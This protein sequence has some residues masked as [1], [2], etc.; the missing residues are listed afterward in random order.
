MK[1]LISILLLGVLLCGMVLPASAAVID[2]VAPQYKKIISIT[3]SFYVDEK[4]GIA[5]CYADCIAESDV[6]IKI[7]G[8]LQQ[9]TNGSWVYVTSWTESG[10]RT[11]TLDEQY[12]VASGYKYRFIA[13][14]YIYDSNGSFVESEMASRIYDYNS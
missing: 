14:F 7:V 1:R 13:Q 10:K 2:P 6:T 11:V 3:T 5:Y 4:T 8:T 9:Y 12:A